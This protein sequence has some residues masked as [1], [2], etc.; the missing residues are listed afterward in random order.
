MARLLSIGQFAAMSGLSPRA[1]RMY[2]ETGLLSPATID[3]E[4]GYRRYHPD[5]LA[6]ARTIALLRR[7]GI[8]LSDIGLFLAD[9]T[10]ERIEAW[11][12][13]I[14]EELE[15]RQRLLGNIRNALETGTPTH[16]EQTVPIEEQQP[17]GATRLSR[18][19]PILASTNIDQTVAFYQESLGFVPVF[20]SDDYAILGR[21]DIT[22]NFWLCE[23]DEIPK[24]T[25]CR[26]QV[27]GVDGLYRECREAG[28]VHPNGHLDDKPWG[29]RE[30]STLDVHG[31]AITFFER[32]GA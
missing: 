2:G 5:Q 11:E 25:A 13:Q 4:S 28:I 1:I 31:N 32:P 29:T 6:R 16:K 30:F 15:S 17:E 21:D 20:E 22:I 7:C 10:P 27:V 18:A 24:H 26:V 8:S 9:P 23:D 3:P 12:Q 14:V 19:V